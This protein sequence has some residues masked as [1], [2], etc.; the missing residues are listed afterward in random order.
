[1]T[2]ASITTKAILICAWVATVLS[3]CLAIEVHGHRGARAVLPENSLAAFEYA[4]EIG[5]DV[6]EL[7]T[8]VSKDGVIVVHHDQMVNRSLCQ[9]KS[10]NNV[11]ENQWI[12]QLSLAELKDYDC[13]SRSNSQF[14]NQ[15]LVLGTEIPTLRE[16]FEL[17]KNSSLPQAGVVRFNIEAKSRE[18][19][20]FAQPSPKEFAD[21]ILQLLN[22]YELQERTILQ[23]FDHRILFE[24][25]KLN[26][27]LTLSALFGK[28]PANWLIHATNIGANIISPHFRDIDKSDVLHIQNAGFKVI[29]W[30][31]NNAKDWDFLIDLGVDGIIT[32]DPEQLIKYLDNQADES[33]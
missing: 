6:I 22:E 2:P 10:G 18:D 15:T 21:K 9:T 30:T 20:P 28:P 23:S 33:F 27:D 13:G 32:D 29:P 31:A 4:I 12:H 25:N 26:A 5:V 7:D 16:V 19:R 24:A 17:V 3:D 8:G 14:P 11:D 1:M